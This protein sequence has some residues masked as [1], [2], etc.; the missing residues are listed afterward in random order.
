MLQYLVLYCREYLQKNGSN[1]AYLSKPIN[2]QPEKVDIIVLTCCTLHNFV[3]HHRGLNFCT[4]ANVYANN[5]RLRAENRDALVPLQRHRQPQVV[6]L[7]C[8]EVQDMMKQWFCSPIGA[9]E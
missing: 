2:L 4:A 7:N 9:I 3:L 1:V 8:R 5:T 6:E